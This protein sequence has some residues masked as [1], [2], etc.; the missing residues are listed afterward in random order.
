[1]LPWQR[2]F[3]SSKMRVDNVRPGLLWRER[4]QLK[5]C[6]RWMRTAEISKEGG[7]VV[8]SNSCMIQTYKVSTYQSHEKPLF[9]QCSEYKFHTCIQ[10]D[11]N[12]YFLEQLFFEKKKQVERRGIVHYQLTFFSKRQACPPR[13]CWS[14]FWLGWGIDFQFCYWNKKIAALSTYSKI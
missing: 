7:D 6:Q 10:I 12:Y 11:L 5:L 13:I 9:C 4:C 14:L 1:M 8:G 2:S 3:S